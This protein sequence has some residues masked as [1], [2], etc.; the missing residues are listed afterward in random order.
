[1]SRRVFSQLVYFSHHQDEEVQLKA[2]TG[3]GFFC[4]RHPELMLEESM[5][6]LYS[7]WLARQAS[8]KK[9]CQVLRNLQCHLKEVETTLKVADVHGKWV[10]C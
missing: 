5:R 3:L 9:K 8:S 2:V 1:M 7:T 4:V 10:V 6:D